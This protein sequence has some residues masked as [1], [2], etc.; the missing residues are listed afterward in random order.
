VQKGETLHIA[1]NRGINENIKQ[2]FNVETGSPPNSFLWLENYNPNIEHES[3][4][5]RFG[6]TPINDELVSL[7]DYTRRVPFTLPSEN[8][9]FSERYAS[10]IVMHSNVILIAN[11]KPVTAHY[12]FLHR[13]NGAVDPLPF[14]HPLKGTFPIID[15]TG[16][17]A[18]VLE[19]KDDG[20]YDIAWHETFADA[21][22]EGLKE[23][24]LGWYTLGT[25]QDAAKFGESLVFVTKLNGFPNI[26]ENMGADEF[27]IKGRYRNLDGEPYLFT[28]LLYPVYMW[29]RWDRSKYRDKS[30]KFY[31]NGVS[32]DGK[33]G[34]APDFKLSGD[35]HL[36]YHT[37]HKVL[38]PSMSYIREKEL[39]ICQVWHGMT[40][41]VIRDLNSY[42]DE[43][44]KKACQVI[45]FEKEIFDNKYYYD[46]SLPP[47]ERVG[48]PVWEANATGYEDPANPGTYLPW[49]DFPYM[50]DYKA[51]G[52]N[53]NIFTI[54]ELNNSVLTG[55]FLNGGLTP[56]R[57]S[58][59][60]E[61]YWD[62]Y[63]N[64][65][66][67]APPYYPWRYYKYWGDMQTWPFNYD[68]RVR[69]DTLT[70]PK[71][72][73]L[74]KPYPAPPPDHE[75]YEQRFI[76]YGFRNLAGE[77]TKHII[78]GEDTDFVDLDG[79]NKS[80]QRDVFFIAMTF[81]LPNYHNLG[82]PRPW[83]SGDIIP[84]VVTAKI[85]GVEVVVAE[86][87][88]V[89]NNKT[90]WQGSEKTALTYPEL[91]PGMQQSR[92]DSSLT[93]KEQLDYGSY[94]MIQLGRTID[95]KNL[96]GRFKKETMATDNPNVCNYITALFPSDPPLPFEY[97]TISHYYNV[98]IT[99]RVSKEYILDTDIEAINVYVQRPDTS[100]KS[101]SYFN[102]IGLTNPTITPPETI[103][104]KPPI[105]KG[106]KT[107]YSTYGLVKSFIIKG[108]G[109][110]IENFD[111]KQYNFFEQGPVAT[112]AWQETEITG[113]V[114]KV[115]GERKIW[116]WIYAVPVT[117]GGNPNPIMQS[118]YTQ[119][120]DRPDQI[121]WEDKSKTWTPDFILWD[122]PLNTPSLQLQSDGEYWHGLGAKLVKVFKGRT[123]IAGCIDKNGDEEVGI[124]RPS[125]V[126][127]ANISPDVFNEMDKLKMG[128]LP[129]TAMEE[130][131]EQLVVFNRQANYRMLLP[132]IG[133]MSTWELLDSQ[134]GQG[135]FSQ[136]TLVVTPYGIVYGNE[137]GIWLGDGRMPVNLA[138]NE[139]LGVSILS[140][141]QK[142]ITDK[143]YIFA[144]QTNPG[145][146]Y[147]ENGWNPYLE[148]TYNETTDELIIVTPVA[149]KTSETDPWIDVGSTEIKL[150]LD[151]ELRLI[152]GFTAKNWRIE[153]YNLY[154]GKETSNNVSNPDPATD[155]CLVKT[156]SK[157][158]KLHYS[159]GDYYSPRVYYTLSDVDPNIIKDVRY[160][161][162]KN[163]NESL[164]D[165]YR[166]II[167]FT[168]DPDNRRKIAGQFITHEYGNGR[169][170]YLLD[171]VML[172]FSG[173]DALILHGGIVAGTHGWSTYEYQLFQD[174]LSLYENIANNCDPMFLV[175]LRGKQW[176]QQWTK[177][178]D[179]IGLNTGHENLYNFKLD[180]VRENYLSRIGELN[181]SPDLAGKARNIFFTS[182]QTPGGILTD[183]EYEVMAN[184]INTPGR[185]SVIL[186]SPL[187]T[188]FRTSRFM[189]L[190]EI[191]VKIK[192]I[193]ITMS[194]MRRRS[195]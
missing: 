34:S 158:H 60:H 99:L 95:S 171:R 183:E 128:S 26:P 76:R 163:N 98:Y 112:N 162:A 71:T 38:K 24:D 21:I 79:S 28:Q 64:N 131:R 33:Q 184:D 16:I 117:P 51:V 132:K 56:P 140:L 145:E 178:K 186:L 109:Q 43:E 82:I 55:W 74:P 14:N 118:P 111:H 189:F 72:M 68:N 49:G 146:V 100:S 149:R 17:T 8:I 105:K 65:Y 52:C 134:Q 185:E 81:G 168:N 150:N 94:Q 181:A 45:I 84:M 170:D 83:M 195:Y 31:W 133:Q 70:F 96:T 155:P 101:G 107:D 15:S 126:Q 57:Q 175:E 166:T 152:Y 35:L 75:Q 2:D 119:G 139:Q 67:Y 141:W 192:S 22:T 54:E 46:K 148:F 129:I 12:M 191:I 73:K 32:F 48:F 41:N 124:V 164:F 89:V 179:T 25:F 53:D 50:A 36:K 187:N 77:T 138:N 59:A 182:L 188:K 116:D 104:R 9:P 120:N 102:H 169:D 30:G 93:K 156:Y 78:I 86:A 11:P 3:L 157:I 113:P 121:N 151:T 144:Q 159:R 161:I 115:F 143:P 194:Q 85:H 23:V 44:C 92:V 66:G 6:I 40:G 130:F 90:D 37:R 135:T 160:E 88:Y 154:Q 173:R 69:H 20:S 47:L 5:K 61:Y 190:S 167:P 123:I 80:H 127:G 91:M 97:S 172:E 177:N 125:A 39:A 27:N 165:F 176:I 137:S 147:I 62:R 122:Y 142:L 42:S 193:A 110:T 13:T 153:S 58:P 87:N 4:I 10:D 7:L 108:E 29:K 103:Y 114:K 63:Y 180:L 106:T 19:Y 18:R 174:Q 1:F 136:K